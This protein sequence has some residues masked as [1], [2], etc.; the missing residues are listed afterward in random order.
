[1]FS[2]S[3]QRYSQTDDKRTTEGNNSLTALSMVDYK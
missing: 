3:T 1:L 2:H